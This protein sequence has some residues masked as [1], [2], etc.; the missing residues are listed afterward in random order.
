MRLRAST[1]TERQPRLHSWGSTGRGAGA[2]LVLVGLAVAGQASVTGHTIKAGETLSGIASRHGVSVAELQAANDIADLHRVIAGR[3]LVIPGAPEAVPTGGHVVAEGETLTVVAA[4]YGVR[5][6]ALAE[7]NG[8]GD[9]DRIFAG[10]SLN[11]PGTDAVPPVAAAV[12]PPVA[13]TPSAPAPTGPEEAAPSGITHVVV[14]GETLSGVASRYGVTSG[15]LGRANQIRNPRALRVG[16]SLS[17]PTPGSPSTPTPG[18]VGGLDTSRF[19]SRLKASPERLALVPRFQRWATTYGVPVDLVMATAWLESGW[20][21]S[22]VSSAGARG[23]GQLMPETVEWMEEELLD[24]E[25][26]ASNPDDNIRMSAAYLAWL[27]ER[28]NGDASTALAGYYQGLRSVRSEGVFR[29][30]RQYVRGV[31]SFRD[32]HF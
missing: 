26:D 4:R 17:I 5:P 31:L 8:L 18:A 14:D 24:T 28:T 25:L 12:A 9:P 29:E 10:R 11:V 32:S 3:T 27:L 16:A 23:I 6:S 21:N 15:A 19:P 7:A 20:Q 22:V 30:S 13:L 2:T 1:K